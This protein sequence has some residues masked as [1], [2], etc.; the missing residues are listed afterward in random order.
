[1]TLPDDDKVTEADLAEARQ[2]WAGA[3]HEPVVAELFA[4]PA[5][6]P[7]FR[8]DVPLGAAGASARNAARKSR[9]KKP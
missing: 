1:M 7:G 3:E 8:G 6:G 4:R 9:R 5:Y 2:R